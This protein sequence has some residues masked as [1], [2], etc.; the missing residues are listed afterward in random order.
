MNQEVLVFTL[1]SVLEVMC[2]SFEYQFF[3]IY[4][5]TGQRT[6]YKNKQFLTGFNKILKPKMLLLLLNKK[7]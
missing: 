6:V 2:P 3:S 4:L 5:S 7:D 1:L